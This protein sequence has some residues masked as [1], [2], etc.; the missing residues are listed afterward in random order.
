MMRKDLYASEPGTE[1]ALASG[2]RSLVAEMK[3]LGLS[4]AWLV[5]DSKSSVSGIIASVI[6]EKAAKGLAKGEAVRIDQSASITLKTALTMP[7]AAKGI[8]ILACHPSKKLLDNLD[9]LRDAA[10][11]IVIPWNES[12]VSQWIKAR[13]PVDILKRTSP[14]PATVSNSVVA[15][16]LESIRHILNFSTGVVDPR[17]KDSV[18]DAF[19]ILRDG[20]E[21]VDADEVRAWF[22][23]KGMKPKHANQIAEIAAEPGKFR[24]HSSNARWKTDILEQWRSG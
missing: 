21:P 7:L 13:G 6:G 14:V 2:V 18:I 5:C 16:A 19:R 9:A 1:D 3:S 10:V 15:R 12:D 8:A 11:L 24:K 17:D 4:H 23:Q 22:V 20:K